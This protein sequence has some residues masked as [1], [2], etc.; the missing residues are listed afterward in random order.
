MD[1][2]TMITVV[3]KY[4]GT[5]GYTVEDLGI[6]RTFYPNEKKDALFSSAPEIEYYYTKDDIKNIMIN[7][8]LDQFLDCLDFAPA[9]VKETIKEMAV[10]LPL[11]DIAKRD[12]ILDKLGFNVTKAIEIKNTKFDGGDEQENTTKATARRRSV[13]LKSSAVPS[14]RRY[15]PESND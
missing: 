14:G 9:A 3:N 1:K 15:R 8:T 2:N 13:P 11:N 5:V 12:A 6:K 10:D 4:G 7:G